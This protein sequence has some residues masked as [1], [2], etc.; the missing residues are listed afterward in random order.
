MKTFIICD[1]RQCAW[2]RQYFYDVHPY[3]IRIANKPLL[4]YMA[5]FAVLAGA[6][7]IDFVIDGHHD[8]IEHYFNDGSRWNIPIGYIYA[9]RGDHIG[10]IFRRH[11]CDCG[12]HG[13]LIINGLFFLHYNKTFN[14]AAAMASDSLN[15]RRATADGRGLHLIRRECLNLNWDSLPFAVDPFPDVAISPIDNIR[16]IFDLN[17]EMVR[18]DAENYTMLSFNN[19]KDVYIGQNVE[20]TRDCAIIPPVIIGSDVQLRDSRIG[21]S[22]IIGDNTLVDT[23]SIVENSVIYS[24]SYIGSSLE[25]QNK[26]VYKRKIADPHSGAAI[27]IV[28][29]FLV[30]EIDHNI[31][32]QFLTVEIQSLYAMIIAAMLI[33]PFILMY[34]LGGRLFRKSRRLK[35]KNSET[36]I[37]IPAYVPDRSNF[38][39]RLFWKFSLD[40]LPLVIR[41]LKGQL[42]L[43]GNRPLTD[44]PE[45]RELIRELNSYQPGAFSYSEMRG[46]DNGMPMH[47][48]ELYY[49]RHHNLAMDA[50]IIIK[51]MILRLFRPTP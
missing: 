46:H 18:G 6:T 31:I 11:S 32:K 14:Y 35:D 5:E 34:P 8:G 51:T 9:A 29:D 33:I 4:E 23:G 42:R 1:T 12:E 10:S 37:T 25:F 20:F 43:V 24:N 47:I 26:I 50:G 48:D 2:I 49:S 13:L 7:E 30:T 3:M 36:T 44:L 41:A 38:L 15:H 28:D 19:E 22:A 40:K 27:D 16:H 45:N 39:R 17:M 21:P